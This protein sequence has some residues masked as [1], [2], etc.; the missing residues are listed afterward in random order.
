MN[1]NYSYDE[2]NIIIIYLCKIL[3]VSLWCT[4]SIMHVYWSVIKKIETQN[5]LIPRG[6]LIGAKE[7]KKTH[8]NYCIAGYNSVVKGKKS[9]TKPCRNR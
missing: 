9:G 8:T 3:T 1:N 5:K 6:T 4:I 2:N 7:K